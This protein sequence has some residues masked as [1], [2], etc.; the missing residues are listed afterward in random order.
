MSPTP[1]RKNQIR[2]AL[3]LELNNAFTKLSKHY[4][5]YGDE[6]DREFLQKL[7]VSLKECVKG[8]TKTREE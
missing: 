5:E 8:E 2:S 3:L 4:T 1:H 7:I 6:R